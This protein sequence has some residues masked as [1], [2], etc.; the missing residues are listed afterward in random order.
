MD[1]FIPFSHPSTIITCAG[2]GKLAGLLY[3]QPRLKGCWSLHGARGHV[4]LCLGVSTSHSY[5]A[6]RMQFSKS[7]QC[8]AA[9]KGGWGLPDPGSSPLRRLPRSQEL[10]P[11][12]ISPNFS[13]PREACVLAEL[14]QRMG[15]LLAPVF[16]AAAC[17]GPAPLV[18]MQMFL[19]A[20]SQQCRADAS[21]L[22]WSKDI[23]GL[24]PQCCC[25]RSQVYT[26]LVIL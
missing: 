22:L 11:P 5:G 21:S 14:R 19:T 20:H 17:I 2:A 8:G 15:G 23:Q 13:M 4:S 16:S 18:L 10:P 26:H 7:G 9:W 25:L 6:V 24:H 3:I 1:S 12:A